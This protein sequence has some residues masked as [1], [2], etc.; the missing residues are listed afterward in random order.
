MLLEGLEIEEPPPACKRKM[1]HE[2]GRS[3]ERDTGD[4]AN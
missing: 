4:G 1:I 3:D 2:K